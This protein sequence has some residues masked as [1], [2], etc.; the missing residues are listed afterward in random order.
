M[1]KDLVNCTTS[2]VAIPAQAIS[3][4]GATVGEVIDLVGYNSGKF[5][6]TTGAVTV[7]DI[8]FVSIEESDVVGMTG[9][10]VIPDECLINKD[11]TPIA[12]ANGVV[13]VGFI[14]SK[15]FVRLN[16]VATGS[17]D[18]LASATVELGHPDNAPTK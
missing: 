2:V 4:A 1:D 3:G 16:V 6:L 18:L 11:E 12:S 15:Q 14:A 17:A 8:A 13:E 9:A 7:G 5:V 10:T